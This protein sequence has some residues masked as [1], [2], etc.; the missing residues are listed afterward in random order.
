MRASRLTIAACALALLAACGPLEGEEEWAEPGE[1]LPSV[2]PDVAEPTPPG[3]DDAE[4]Q[5]LPQQ[6]IADVRESE[7]PPPDDQWQQP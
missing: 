3:S 2:L 5:R 4:V 1:E 7:I 6:W